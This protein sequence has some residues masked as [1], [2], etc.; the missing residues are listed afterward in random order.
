MTLILEDPALT[1]VGNLQVEVAAIGV[2]TLTANASYEG[3]GKLVPGALSQFRMMDPEDGRG[4]VR[5]T[6]E[7]KAKPLKWPGAT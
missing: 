5:A 2:A 7:K 1:A 3:G 6:Q 4:D